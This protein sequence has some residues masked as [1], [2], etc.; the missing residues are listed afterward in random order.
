MNTE[1]GLADSVRFKPIRNEI[2]LVHSGIELVETIVVS[3]LCV[4]NNKQNRGVIAS[5]HQIELEFPC[6][7]YVK[8]LTMS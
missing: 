3:R 4:F 2:E 5:L 1:P 8:G 6:N 7:A